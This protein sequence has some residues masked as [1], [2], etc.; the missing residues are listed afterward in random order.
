MTT[1]PLIIF[2]PDFRAWNPY[3]TLLYE[4][5]PATPVSEFQELLAICE[6]AASLPQI[7]HLHWL[8]P[9]TGLERARAT[10]HAEALQSA[11]SRA[12]DGGA[13]LVFTV[14]NMASHEAANPDL[15]RSLTA[16]L[17]KQAD[18]VH[19]HHRS[20]IEPLQR[21]LGPV[22]GRW[23]VAEHGPYR[24]TASITAQA[25][26]EVFDLEPD[27]EIIAV[28]GQLRAYKNIE[29]IAEV[30]RDWAPPTPR[31]RV[32]FVGGITPGAD[33]RLV[34]QL[35]R[36]PF[37][38]FGRRILDHDEFSAM[39]QQAR[40]VWLSY[41]EISTSGS[42]FH[43]VSAGTPVIA[44]ALG[45]LPFYMQPG[46]NGFL[47]A[48]GDVSTTRAW[49]TLMA[50][51]NV[52]SLRR[53]REGA[54]RSVAH[55][56]WADVRT[57]LFGAFETSELVTRTAVES[58]TASDHWVII[59]PGLRDTL[60]HHHALNE[61]LR[62]RLRLE[63]VAVSVLG[64]RTLLAS[65]E[66]GEAIFECS[67]YADTPT[68]DEVPYQQLVR[69]HA[70]DLVVG[71][72][73]L[74]R[75]VSRSTWV[76]HTT[77]AGL[78]Q[79]LANVLARVATPPSAILVQLM[80]HPHSFGAG[81]ADGGRAE[82][83]YALALRALRSAARNRG[84][85]L[86]L[87]SSCQSFVHTFE[88][89]SG[90]TVALHPF[91]LLSESQRLRYLDGKVSRTERTVGQEVLLYTGDLKL[92]KGA[93]WMVKAVPALLRHFHEVFFTV[94]WSSNRFRDPALDALG[95][96]LREM[97]TRHSRLRLLEGPLSPHEW[98]RCLQDASLMVLPYDPTVYAMR[99]SGIFWERLFWN[100]TEG[101]LVVTAGSWMAREAD[102]TGIK[103]G[104][105]EYGDDSSLIEE[106]EKGLAS[107]AMAPVDPSAVPACFA[108]GNDEFLWQQWRSIGG[109]R[110]S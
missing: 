82:R 98:E 108:Q 74:D 97:A 29:F 17:V 42:L 102:E 57:R 81:G 73:R 53:W 11:L 10:Q 23:V 26:F 20:V 91:V 49:L 21:W 72:S 3:Q 15:E 94:H 45:T 96:Q 25:L 34:D 110:T 31:T 67:L 107:V 60:T 103:V 89:L 99:T 44:P 62:G 19:V 58:Q 27:A 63:N 22:D 8:S 38:R 88:A 79:A 106:I 51:A 43:A 39:V 37:V 50:R 66:A 1:V 30:L 76:V 12:R 95:Y 86:R 61:S 59:D 105:C 14:H 80:F 2:F 32:V 18:V 84:V 100:R 46:V 104:R 5:L 109:G 71:L 65:P 55:L 78:L 47:H 83:R 54:A 52:E 6:S 4:G 68:L 35:R 87:S 40:A 9:I 75:T 16:W 28:P 7:V 92:E 93:G 85:E 24:H 36:L 56:N 70:R 69:A 77:T 101:S 64:H 48:P 41:R 13:K 33:P 90:A